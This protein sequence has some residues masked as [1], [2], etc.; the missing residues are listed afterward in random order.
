MGKKVPIIPPL[1]IDTNITSDFEA[2]A[3]YFNIFC[4]SMYTLNNNTANTKLSFIKL[5]NK[6]II[7]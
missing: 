6:D 2:K 3:N 1:L 5:E 4:V 7:I